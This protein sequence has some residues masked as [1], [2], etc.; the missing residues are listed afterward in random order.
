MSSRAQDFGN[1]LHRIRAEVFE[2][3]LREFS[4]RIGL[5]ASYINKI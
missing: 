2:E 3:S 5:S 4:K 1:H